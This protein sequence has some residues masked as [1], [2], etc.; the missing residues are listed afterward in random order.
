MTAY[1]ADFN[2]AP[3]GVSR[4][5]MRIVPNLRTLTGPYT[6]T[7]QVL[8]L[9]GERWAVRFDLIPT[10]DVGAAAA[11]EAFFDRLKGQTHLFSTWHLAQGAPQGTLR[12]GGVTLTFV[13]GSSAPLAFT[14]AGGASITFAS[15]SAVLAAAVAQLSNAATIQTVA[16]RTVFAGDML[17]INE[18]LVRVMADATANGSG[19]LTVEFQP[20]ART[21]WP[22]GSRVTTD[23]PTANFMLRTPDGV[24]T[25]FSPGYTDGVS[26]EAIEVPA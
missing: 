22:V 6:P 20:R 10:T 25:V 11:R 1:A 14:G 19:V 4:F 9:L 26:V 21:A 5:E 2:A 7:T 8:D 15:G 3:W 23:R 17:G 18:Q 24:P 13:D 12:T 16:G